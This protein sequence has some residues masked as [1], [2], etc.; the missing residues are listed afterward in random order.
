[1]KRWCWEHF[2]SE[3]LEEDA[4][5]VPLP[6]SYREPSGYEEVAW[7]APYCPVGPPSSSALVARGPPRYPPSSLTLVLIGPPQESSSSAERESSRSWMG[8]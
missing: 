3:Y 8:P 5:E 7:E 2:S 6:L 1:M 4:V